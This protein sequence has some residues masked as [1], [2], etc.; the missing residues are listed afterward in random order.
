MRGA[1]P[2]GL[3][4]FLAAYVRYSTHVAAYLALAANPYPGFTGAPG[5]PVDVEIPAP[6]AA[7]SLEDRR[8]VSCSRSRP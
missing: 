8:C 1:A 4:N 5:Y 3:H 2:D 7:G 6:A